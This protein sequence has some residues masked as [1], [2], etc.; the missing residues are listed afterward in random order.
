MKKIVRVIGA[1]IVDGEGRVL[2]A[3]RPC[4]KDAYKSLKWELPGGK[5][6]EGETPEEAIIREIR[7]ELGCGITVDEFL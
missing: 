4:S 2:A 7:E 6:E 5:L 3:Q 1:V